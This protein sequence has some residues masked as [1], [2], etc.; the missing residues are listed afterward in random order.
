[1]NEL[2]DIPATLDGIEIAMV[3]LV[4]IVAGSTAALVGRIIE[5]LFIRPW[6][7]RRGWYE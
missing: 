3:I 1:M 7:R 2:P 5:Y 6:A 4:L